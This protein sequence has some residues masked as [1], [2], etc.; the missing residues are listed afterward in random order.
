M[1][2]KKQDGEPKPPVKRLTKGTSLRLSDSSHRILDKYSER[3]Q[4]TKASVMEMSL[5]LFEINAER[6]ESRAARR[7]IDSAKKNPNKS[8]DS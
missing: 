3:L 8:L 5:H 6:D 7:L 2:R 1:A 4:V